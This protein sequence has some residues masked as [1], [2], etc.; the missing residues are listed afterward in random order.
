MYLTSKIRK[1]HLVINTLIQI[2]HDILIAG[3]SALQFDGLPFLYACVWNVRYLNGILQPVILR[4]VAGRSGAYSRRL[5]KFAP[6]LSSLILEILYAALKIKC[7][8]QKY[9]VTS[10]VAWNFGYGFIKQAVFFEVKFIFFRPASTLQSV[11]IICVSFEAFCQCWGGNTV[12]YSVYRHIG[13]VA[14]LTVT[15]N[16]LFILRVYMLGCKIN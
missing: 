16:I 2:F 7:P 15:W 3:I 13:L 4:L 10:L 12:V 14:Q 6:F 8:N 9:I 1:C 11:R 5:I